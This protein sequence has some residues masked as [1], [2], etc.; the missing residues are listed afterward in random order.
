M[1]LPKNILCSSW[2]P[3]EWKPNSLQCL[4][5]SLQFRCPETSLSSLLLFFPLLTLAATT[6]FLFFLKWLLGFPG[7]APLNFCPLYPKSFF[8]RL[9]LCPILLPFFHLNVVYPDQHISGCN[10]PL[11]LHNMPFCQSVN[12]L[13]S[14]EKIRLPNIWK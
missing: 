13:N 5:K 10:P 12:E 2:F 4:V 14:L 1:F 7:L 8:L 9:P 11:F 6:V 3:L